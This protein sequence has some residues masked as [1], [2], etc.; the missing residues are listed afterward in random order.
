M[1]WM[2]VGWVLEVVV[3]NCGMIAA[4]TADKLGCTAGYRRKF[5]VWHCSH[6]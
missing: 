5:P 3:G 6:L 1:R 4:S 2:R